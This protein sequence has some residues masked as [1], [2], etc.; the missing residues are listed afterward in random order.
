MISFDEFWFIY[1]RKVSKKD[2]RRAWDRAVKV[3]LPDVIYSGLKRQ[4]EYLAS[5]PIE[6]CPHAA[7][8]LNGER[9]EDEI[10]SGFQ[11]S[12]SPQAR[13]ES[14]FAKHQRECTEALERSV[15]GDKKDE[16]FASNG[17]A[18]DLEPGNWR[19]H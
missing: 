11:P 6:F 18:F 16:Q 13:R 19:P 8:W 17:A 2:A 3:E 7:T 5:R 12:G 4:L 1:P 15:Y 10:P 9:W 14:D